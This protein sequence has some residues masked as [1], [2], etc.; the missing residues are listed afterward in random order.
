[1]TYEQAAKMLSNHSN[2]YRPSSL[3]GHIQG[4]VHWTHV[5]GTSGSTWEDIELKLSAIRNWLGY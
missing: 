4:L 3:A 1:M 2:D 5:N